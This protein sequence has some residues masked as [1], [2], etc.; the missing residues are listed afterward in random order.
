MSVGDKEDVLAAVTGYLASISESKPPFANVHKYILPESYAV[1][2]RLGGE[3]VQ[4]TLAELVSRTE[5]EAD[6]LY[7]AGATSVK[8]QLVSPEPDIWV[9]GRFA[10]AWVRYAHQVDGVEKLRGVSAYTLFK[11]DEGWK[12]G[13]IADKQWAAG[14]AVPEVKEVP[15][16]MME[17]NLELCRLLNEEKWDVVGDL[18]LPGGGATYMRYPHTLLMLEWP[19]FFAKM[20]VMLE[21]AKPGYVEQELLD[22]EGRV[23]G[24]VGLVWTPFT[25]A[26]DGEVRIR[27]YNIFSMLKK[28]G[29]WFIS[30]A[31]DG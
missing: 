8:T 28:D 15:A 19:D 24:D 12:I 31:Q 7:K 18:M 6:D 26:L 25:V 10:A 3:L 23:C 4:C 27:G 5:R 11:R 9:G 14:D 2:V 16:D 22:W 21:K 17:P 29:K 1:L 13:A 20:R 30:G